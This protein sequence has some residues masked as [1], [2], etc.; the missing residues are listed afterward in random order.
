ME[1][2]DEGRTCVEQSVSE[3]LEEEM[4]QSGRIGNYWASV[5]SFNDDFVFACRERERITSL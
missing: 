1:N 5:S 4:N 2:W 3:K